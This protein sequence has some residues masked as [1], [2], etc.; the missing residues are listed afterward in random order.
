MIMLSRHGEVK[1]A[2][3]LSP[4]PIHL[5]KYINV[6]K[7]EEKLIIRYQ[8]ENLGQVRLQTHF[9]SEW[10]LNMLGGGGNPQA[11][12][13]LDAQSQID[14]R[15]DSSGE[16]E[17]LQELRVGNT[18]LQQEI[19]FLIN[20]P[21]TLWHFSIDTVTGSEAGFERTHQGSNFTFLWPIILDSGSTWTVE[22]IVQGSVLN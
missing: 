12:C 4:L 7:G 16:T 18:W 11:Y 20:L 9:A 19:G 13:T 3:A 5:S 2:G 21:T 15:F 8:I 1:R 6:P 10:N 14:N 22:I 17:N